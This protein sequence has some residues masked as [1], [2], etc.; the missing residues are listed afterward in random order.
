MDT[1]PL[2]AD[3][4][5]IETHDIDEHR[6]AV[7]PWELILRQLSPGAFAAQMDFVHLNGILI[8]PRALVAAR[9]GD[10]RDAAGLLHAG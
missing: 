7:Q 10:R 9:G 2:S 1:M 8:L 3:V 4:G 6:Q 5:R